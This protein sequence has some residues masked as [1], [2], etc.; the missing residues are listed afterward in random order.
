MDKQRV[1]QIERA[2]ARLCSEG[3]GRLTPE[4]V[5]KEA[6]DPS[7][8]LHGEF[9]WDNTEAARLYRLQQARQL[10]R[11]VKVEVRVEHKVLSV[12]R[13]VHDETLEKGQR[14]YVEAQKLKGHREIALDTLRAEYKQ[15]VARVDRMLGVAEQV[16][17][18]DEAQDLLSR[19]GNFQRRLDEAA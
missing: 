13:F 18:S 14:G 2:L 11:V 9:V 16:G 19:L 8:P 15:I 4:A 3:G 5:V 7:S 6:E 10:I 1:K 12:P 17:L